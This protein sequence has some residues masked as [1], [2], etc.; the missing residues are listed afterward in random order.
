MKFMAN[1]SGGQDGA[2]SG[3]RLSAAEHARLD[4][5]T[6]TIATGARGAAVSHQRAGRLGLVQGR[7]QV[8]D[9]LTSQFPTVGK[10][11]MAIGHQQRQLAEGRGDAHAPVGVAGPADLNA[12]RLAIVGDDIAF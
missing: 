11:Q 10:R 8:P 4:S 7:R 6:V 1:G 2:G 12:R 5:Y 9:F 3:H